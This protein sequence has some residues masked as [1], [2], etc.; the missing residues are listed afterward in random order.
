MKLEDAVAL[1]RNDVQLP[2]KLFQ[3]VEKRSNSAD[4]TVEIWLCK[5][6]NFTYRAPIHNLEVGCKQGHDMK[7][8]WI[9]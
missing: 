3:Q 5:K 7:R 9:I 8:I 1:L 4:G 2:Y 6:C